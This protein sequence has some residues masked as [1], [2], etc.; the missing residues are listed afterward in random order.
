MAVL[1]VDDSK[2]VRR[3]Y[4]A[5]LAAK[6]FAVDVVSSG[7][8]GLARLAGGAYDVV[9][10]DLKMPGMGGIEFLR[11]VQD[12][13]PDLPVIIMTGTPTIHSAAEAVEHRAYRYLTKSIHLDDLADALRRARKYYALAQ[14]KREALAASGAAAWDADTVT[15]ERSFNSALGRLWVAFQ[16]IVSWPDRRVHGYEVLMRSDEGALPLPEQILGAAE[17][18][19][20]LLELGRSVR[21]HTAVA[22]ACLPAD[23]TLFVN[24]HPIDLNDPELYKDGPLTGIASRVV[25]EITERASLEAVTSLSQRLQHLRSLGFRLA[26]DDLGAG[27]A[28]LTSMAHLEPEYVKLDMSLVRGI[29]EIPTKQK[30][31]QSMA[32][33]CEDL[34]MQVVA[35]GIETAAERDVLRASGCGLLQGYFFA[36]PESHPPSVNW[37]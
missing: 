15:L 35:E 28:G 16:P 37:G 34:G 27:Y 20:R 32:H 3:A 23:S 1:I 8:E 12:I 7:P 6:G 21:A 17:R 19:G 2:F 18:L 29:D 22:L 14:L 10:S 5:G 36:R 33:L 11:A 4:Q 24:L 30:V 13:D 26:V 31:V 9:V 25:L